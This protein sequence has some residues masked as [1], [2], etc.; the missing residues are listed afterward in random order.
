[1]AHAPLERLH[2]AHRRPDDGHHVDDAEVLGEQPV[3]RLHHVADEE[4]REAHARLRGA[5][6]RRGGEAVADG[7]GRHHEILVRVE[8]LAGADE[9]VQPVV[10][11]ADRSDHQDRV[12]LLRV[13]LAVRH[14]G[15]GKVLDHIAALEL[16]VA[17]LSDL[18][19]RLVGTVRE[20][21]AGG[22]HDDGDQTE[23][24]ES[25]HG[26]LLGPRV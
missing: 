4:L 20:R 12:R 19:G 3:L 10:V 24:D 8:R 6:A 16:Q 7:V 14:I 22:Q 1:M 13:Q 25:G 9:E 17:E 23:R 2:A 11:A 18:V 5:G 21:E 26:L 15:D